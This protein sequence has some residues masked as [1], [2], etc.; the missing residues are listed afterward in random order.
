MR[1]L[2]PHQQS[3]KKKVLWF[4][5]VQPWPI[6]WQKAGPAVVVPAGVAVAAAADVHARE[7]KEGRQNER[8]NTLLKEQE[9]GCL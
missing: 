6:P 7:N 9:M 2:T 1:V 3:L 4:L 8:Q 5:T